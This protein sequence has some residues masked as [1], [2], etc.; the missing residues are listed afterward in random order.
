[1]HKHSTWAGGLLAFFI[2]AGV[3]GAQAPA[4]ASIDAATRRAV[5]DSLAA[6][7]NQ[8]YVDADTGRMIADK[9]H[10]RLAAG[11]YDNATDP[12]RFSDVLTTDLQSV[13]GDRH[14]NTS[15]APP[16]A[17]SNGP[18][19]VGPGG[20]PSNEAGRRDHWGL[21]RVDVLPGNVGYMKVN[22]F[23]GSP[24][25]MAATSAALKF[26][27]GTDAMIFDFRG[28]GGG[29]AEQSNFL[30]SHFVG[31]D[32][33]PSLVVTDRSRGTRR[34]RYTLASV[35]GLRRTDIPVWILTDR[36]TASAGEDFSF[37]LQRLGRATVV[38][39]RT[40]GAGH[41]NATVPLGAG[42]S[43]SISYTRVA[44]ARTGAEWERVGV[45]PDVRANP[46]DAL[47]VAHLAAL[48]LLLR[49]TT[50]AAARVALAAAR[51]SVDALA[52]P[53]VVAA[54]TL[55]SYAGTYEGGRV[56]ALENGALVYRR[57]AGRPPRAMVAVNDSTFILNSAIQVVF[58]RDT[59]GMRM[60][61]KLA[62]GS[63]FAIPRIG[64]VPGELAP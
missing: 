43:A 59:S 4:P 44:D 50:D 5:V 28:M 1:V 39:D 14:L 41:N 33:V 51:L 32:T 46:G 36:G 8:I 9:L 63:L 48:D 6:R 18:R 17:G 60:V 13:N 22:A 37:V 31:A 15:Y 56:I 3:C 49:S 35:P 25:A 54:Q 42:F 23:D 30:I 16:G 12:R 10:A 45:Q 61:Q 27:E 2:T 38:G 62:D 7:L 64:E 21:G 26:L 57:D 24:A 20:P 52:H 53:R 40:A 58:E 47:T 19:R 55:A 29:S 11:A 34:V